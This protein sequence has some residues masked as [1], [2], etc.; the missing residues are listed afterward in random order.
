MKNV[1]VNYMI[2]T[3]LLILILIIIYRFISRAINLSIRRKIIAKMKLQKEEMDKLKDK[4]KLNI[5]EW[6]YQRFCNF[7]D[8]V[9]PS[10]EDFDKKINIII[11]AINNK[12]ITDLD[13]ICEMTNCN[14]TELILKI[15]YLKNKRIIA[16]IYYIDRGE[17][18][19]R[20]CSD[21]DI[22][23]FKKYEKYIY[24]YHSQPHQIAAKMPGATLNTIST[25]ED[26]IINDLIYLD[27]KYIITGLNI[28][29]VD[30]KIIYYSVE[31]HKKER[32]YISLNCN[33]CGA[34]VEVPHFGKERCPYCKN[35]VVDNVKNK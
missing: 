7:F 9:K 25:L 28:D 21:G 26:K 20:K 3:C 29:K 34:L 5:S 32:N 15:M 4:G 13:E 19:L 1:N 31:K 33:K 2:I 23:L 11:D 30:R 12:K 6:S 8:E 27:D 14:F 17:H 24:D 22:A 16:P 35:I 10:D 18:V